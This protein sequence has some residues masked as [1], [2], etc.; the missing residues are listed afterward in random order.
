VLRT[1][2]AGVTWAD[3][4][5]P[6]AHVA[7]AERF[8]FLDPQR[9][10]L[11]TYDPMTRMGMELWRTV[12]GGA[13]WTGSALSAIWSVNWDL[14]FLSPDLG[15]LASDPGGEAPK[16]ELRWSHDGGATWDEPFDLATATGVSTMGDLTFF[17]GS[18]G[19]MTWSGGGEP[20]ILRTAD[21]GRTWSPARLSSTDEVIVNGTPEY[22][23]LQV[24]DATKGLLV[25][26]RLDDDNA[27][28]GQTIYET[29]DAGATWIARYGDAR[30]RWWAFIDESDWVATDGAEVWRTDDG[31]GGWSGSSSTGLPVTLLSATMHFVDPMHGWAQAAGAHCPTGGT[32]SCTGGFYQ[33]LKTFDGGTTWAPVGDCG[34]DT[35]VPC[36]SAEPN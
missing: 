2:D 5:P 21:G 14:R 11:A 26:D 35:F 22:S 30:R 7:D 29:F 27:H 34:E 1:S 33:L 4:T 19:V 13:T 28:L 23:Q 20:G 36:P 15:W 24:I 12:D 3:I 31:G 9:G 10:W 17:D 16:P 32:G 6:D 8:F 18:N 25:V